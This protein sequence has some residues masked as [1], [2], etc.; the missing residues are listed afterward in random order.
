MESVALFTRTTHAYPSLASV[1]A[2]IAIAWVISFAIIARNTIPMILSWRTRV[3]CFVFQIGDADTLS[4]MRK[5]TR[6]S[7]G[8]ENK[9]GA[10]KK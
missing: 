6:Q 7:Y 10:G 8:G 4:R 5:A 9:C 3:D 1:V 2:S